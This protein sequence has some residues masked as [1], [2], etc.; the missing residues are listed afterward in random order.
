M[1]YLLAGGFWLL[2]GN[3]G[4]RS[5]TAMAIA[6]KGVTAF[7]G[8]V[9]DAFR[10]VVAV[11]AALAVRLNV[12]FIELAQRI[13]QTNRVV[14]V[15][16][17]PVRGWTPALVVGFLFVF[18]ELAQRVSQT[19]RAAALLGPKGEGRVR[20]RQQRD[21]VRDDGIVPSAGAACAFLP[22]AG[23]TVR[24]RCIRVLAL[25]VFLKEVV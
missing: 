3:L 12:I 20:G 15:V 22:G 1:V 18:I 14:V 19:D 5:G 10:T 6:V 17:A 21:A 4:L 25:F 13:S 16:V 8:A 23:T 7:D 11:T 2:E 24:G 9:R